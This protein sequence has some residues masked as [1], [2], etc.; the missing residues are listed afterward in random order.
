[1]ITCPFCSK[2]QEGNV[3]SGDC[4]S[5]CSWMQA[6]PHCTGPPSS[7]PAP[8]MESQLFR[9]QLV[10]RPAHLQIWDLTIQGP[11]PPASDIW[12]HHCITGDLFKFVHFRTHI[13]PPTSAH[14]WWLFEAHMVSVGRC[15]WVLHI[16][17]KSFLVVI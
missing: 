11:P 13:H 6:G 15:K 1:M 10:G 14:I 9:D 3:H 12:W 5:F 7:A 17:L 4:L 2:W 16:L 8:D